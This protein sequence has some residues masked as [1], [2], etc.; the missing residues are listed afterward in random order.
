[1]SIFKPILQPDDSNMIQIYKVNFIL[2]SMAVEV[3]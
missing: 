2:I 3:V 1:M